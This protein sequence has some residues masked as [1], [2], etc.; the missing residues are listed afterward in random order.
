MNN[1]EKRRARHREA[2]NVR[3]KLRLKQMRA[4]QKRMNT[5]IRKSAGKQGKMI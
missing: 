4:G 2:G 5:S 1:V 3:K